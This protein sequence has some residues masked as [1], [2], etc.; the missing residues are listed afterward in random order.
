MTGNLSK[1]EYA[2]LFGYF[3]AFFLTIYMI[4]QVYK[5]LK[6]K[7]ASS[8]AWGWL[9][10]DFMTSGCFLV[11]GILLVSYPIII[12]D[13]SSLTGILILSIAKYHFEILNPTRTIP[14]QPI[15]DGANENNLIS[16]V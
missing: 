8:F 2:D 7:D 13:C 4:P 6:T 14:I 11:Y 10:L 5:T 1:E 16:D 3:G 15:V 9:L 12:A